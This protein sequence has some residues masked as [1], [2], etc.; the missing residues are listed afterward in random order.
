MQTQETRTLLLDAGYTPIKTISWQRAVTLITLGKCEIV[1]QYDGFVRSS[2]LVIKIPAVVRLLRVFKRFRKSVKFSR[3][4]IFARDGFKCQYCGDKFTMSELTFDHVTPRSQGGR[5]NWQNVVSCCGD[6]NG[7][8]ANRTPEQAG[9]RLLSKPIEPTWVPAVE[10]RIS[11]YST[12]D[13][14]RSYLY[15]SSELVTA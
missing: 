15:W 4:N 1:E 14:W 6:C 11:S 7:D 13:E 10:I 8:K 3:T 12:P 9:M 5:T 2:S